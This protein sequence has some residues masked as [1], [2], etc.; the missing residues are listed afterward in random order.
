MMQ[1]AQ[2]ALSQNHAYQSVP[3][4]ELSQ[5]EIAIPEN[6]A[7]AKSMNFASARSDLEKSAIRCPAFFP[8]AI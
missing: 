1:T 6:G 7:R 8:F 2:P 4:G 5:T 3:R